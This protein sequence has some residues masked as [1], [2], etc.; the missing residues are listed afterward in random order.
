MP[1]SQ[2][3]L[4]DTL[5]NSVSQVVKVLEHP[6]QLLNAGFWLEA[7]DFL[8]QFGINL[9]TAILI[10]LVGFWIAKQ[11]RLGLTRLFQKKDIEPSLQTF[12]RSLISILIKVM[13]IITAL[14]QLGIEMTS[15]VAL[16]GA[17]GLAIGMAFSGTLSNF[18]GGVIIL[19]FKPYRVGD[20]IQTQ[21][22]TGIVKEILI[23]NTIMNTTDNKRIILPNGAIA[24]GNITNFTMEKMRRVDFS[25]GIAYGDDFKVARDTLMRFIKE[26][27]RIL[28]EPEPFVAL[29]SLGDSS[30]NITVR[31][32]TSTENYWPVFF[33]M[34]ERVYTEFPEHG[35]HIP[36]PQMDVH[37]KQ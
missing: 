13:V 14:Y 32:W 26:D 2:D 19:L 4:Q 28:N 30:V 21:G 10:L 36:F 20:F 8:I 29:G 17:A 6:D 16:L 33:A 35:L 25:Y 22:E 12:L 37:L 15:F 1:N 24:N 23:F 9:G 5:D 27:D 7:K 34:N 31:V 18:A 3:T 11:V